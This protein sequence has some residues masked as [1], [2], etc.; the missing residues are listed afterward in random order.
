MK[1][2]FFLF[3]TGCAFV[4]HHQ[5]GEIKSPPNHVLKKFEILV[6]E[7]GFSIQEAGTAAKYMAGDKKTG[8]AA[9]SIA[10]IVS[11]F[12]MGPRTGN[13]VWSSEKYADGLFE[14]LYEKCPS[15]QVTALDSTRETNKYPVVSGEIIK[16]TGYCIMPKTNPERK[17]I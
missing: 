12:Q 3:L 6:A 4:H 9:E 5:V 2:L 15:G 1:K 10:A 16:V 11:L 7:T 17:N 8:D 14:K 13:P